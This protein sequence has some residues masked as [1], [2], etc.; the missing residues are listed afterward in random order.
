MSDRTGNLR[1]S[2]A[3]EVVPPGAPAW[4][5]PELMR[6]TRAYF[7]PRYKEKLTPD[8]VLAMLLN[9]AHFGKALQELR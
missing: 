9:L 8:R 2:P 4:V 6:R 3:P 7:E 1:I 5:T